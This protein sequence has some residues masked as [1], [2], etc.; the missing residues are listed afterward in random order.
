MSV[1]VL[2]AVHQHHSGVKPVDTDKDNGID[3]G[4]DKDIDKCK[5]KYKYKVG[6]GFDKHHSGVRPVEG[7]GMRNYSLSEESTER[8][9]DP[10]HPY[11]DRKTKTNTKWETGSCLKK[12][13]RGKGRSSASRPRQRY[14]DKNKEKYKYMPEENTE[15]QGDSLHPDPDEETKTKTKINTNTNTCLK[16]I[17]RGRVILCI[18]TQTKAP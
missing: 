8:Y 7:F 17:Q 13:Q 14:K 9:G 11:L 6:K 3:K 10:L 5:D 12:I 2:P 18:Q 15:G 1:R 4:K 16:K